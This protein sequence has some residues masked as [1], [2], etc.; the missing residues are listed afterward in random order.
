MILR[1][2]A[3][4]I[5]MAVLGASAAQAHTVCTAVADAGT[6]KILLQ[7]GDCATRVTPAST[8]KIAISLM[9]FD[10]G[11]LKDAHTP[12]LP[13]Q[14]GYVD[15][16]G[17]EWKKPT[18]PARWIK[19]SVVWFSQQVTQHLGA[20][21]FQ[22]YA[23][24]LDYGNRDLS[25]DPG[26][27]NGLLRSWIGSSLKISPLE[28]VGFLAKLVDRKLPVSGRAIDVT[29]EITRLDPLANGWTLNGKTG[30]AFPKL[31]DGS[32]DEDH[33]WGWFVGWVTKDGRTLTFARLIQDDG[34]VPGSGGVR[35]RDEFL[36]EL[37]ELVDKLA[38]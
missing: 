2:A 23:D 18:D 34:K 11:F 12:T 1:H 28:Q 14:E 24:A 22:K 31:A 19:Y 17:A 10:S 7:Q 3:L 26:K 29:E 32:N 8:F 15:W 6:G 5:A 27:N 9:G 37:P 21:G 13:F 36:K 20:A 16:G 4:G 30:S 38:R 33:G 35:A 25:G